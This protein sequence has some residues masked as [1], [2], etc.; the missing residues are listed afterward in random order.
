MKGLA[1]WPEHEWGAEKQ[2]TMPTL[3]VF[4]RVSSLRAPHKAS[5]CM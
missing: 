3:L 2:L 4:P 5:D 1:V